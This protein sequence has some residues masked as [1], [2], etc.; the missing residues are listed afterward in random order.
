MRHQDERAEPGYY[1]VRRQDHK[2]DVELTASERVGLHRYRYNAGV[3]AKVVLDLRSSIY[4]YK[5]KNLWSHLR[6]RDNTLITGM[7]ETR[8]WA[9]GRQRYF[10]LQFSR[11]FTAR[12]L[13]NREGA[14]EYRGFAGPGKGPA[15]K[16]YVEGKG[17]AGALD[18]GVPP[19][20]QLLVKVALSA[21]S[22]DGAIANLA[23]MPGW[24]VDAERGSAGAAWNEALSV[25]SVEAPEPMRALVYTSLYHSMLAPTLFMDRDG[26]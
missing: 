20:R 4:D 12:E 14:V 3:N 10:A 9:A 17:L 11:P 21:V 2:V 7:R 1:A 25:V 16:V 24:D 13:H 5:A 6:V 15:D 8:G 26:R 18:F 23:E 19:D 22:E